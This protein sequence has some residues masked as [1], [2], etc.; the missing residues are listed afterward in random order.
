MTGGKKK[1]KKK[2]MQCTKFAGLRGGGSNG[3]RDG[4]DFDCFGDEVGNNQLKNMNEFESTF[5]NVLCRFSLKMG[6]LN[7]YIDR[8]ID[9]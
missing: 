8:Q 5:L 9:R 4:S 7:I 3:N 1:K 6:I 2:K